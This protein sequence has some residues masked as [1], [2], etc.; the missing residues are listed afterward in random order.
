MLKDPPMLVFLHVNTVLCLLI[1]PPPRP[2]AIKLGK[3]L[4]DVFYLKFHGQASQLLSK[5]EAH[6]ANTRRAKIVIKAALKPGLS[7][8]TAHSAKA[9]AFSKKNVDRGS[10]F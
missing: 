10:P 7:I 1:P 9:T 4:L 5:W 8:L 3:T 2:I 6:L